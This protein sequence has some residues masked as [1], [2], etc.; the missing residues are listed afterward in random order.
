MR[1]EFSAMKET[2]HVLLALSPPVDGPESEFGH[3]S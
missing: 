3:A 2:Y 1:V